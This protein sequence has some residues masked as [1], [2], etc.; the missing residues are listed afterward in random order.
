MLP[1]PAISV[2]EPIPKP[3]RQCPY[4]NFVSPA[5]CKFCSACGAALH[6]VPCPHC[7]VVNDIDAMTAC[8]RCHGELRESGAA[9]PPALA[10]PDERDAPTPELTESA[11]AQPLD[12][13]RLHWAIVVIVFL[14][15]AAASYY[16]YQQRT[17]IDVRGPPPALFKGRVNPADAGAHLNSGSGVIGRVP[18]EAVPDPATAV[19]APALPAGAQKAMPPVTAFTPQ[20][21]VKAAKSNT[22]ARPRHRGTNANKSGFVRNA[23]GSPATAPVVVAK[24]AR[25]DTNKGI[26]KQSPNIRPCTA[27]VAALGLCTA[28]STQRSQ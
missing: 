9:A 24:G 6:L 1:P 8:Y 2:V 18:A 13:Q 4:C 12:R 19:P 7:G 22:E 26:E 28:E 10:A 21:A 25:I 15:V 3:I 16:A 5:S 27:A 23:A 14:A 11:S 20:V 17:A